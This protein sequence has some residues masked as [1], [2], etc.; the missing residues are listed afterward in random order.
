MVTVKRDKCLLKETNWA[1]IGREMRIIDL[2][3]QVAEIRW[4]KD[5]YRS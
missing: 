5:I 1:F 2:K 3:E 4:R